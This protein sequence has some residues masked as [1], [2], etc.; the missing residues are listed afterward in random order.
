MQSLMQQGAMGPG[1]MHGGSDE[2]AMMGMG[3]IGHV[4]TLRMILALVD[5]NGDGT[6][7]R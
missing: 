4:P 5:A 2:Q 7:G 6:Q 3:M 1:M